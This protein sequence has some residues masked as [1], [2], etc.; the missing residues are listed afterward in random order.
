MGEGFDNY[1]RALA[2]YRGE[3]YAA[4]DFTMSGGTSIASRVAK[5]DGAAWQAVPGLS[6]SNGIQALAV[7]ED[8][9]IVSG[10]VRLAPSG[11]YSTVSSW[12][13]AAW[14]RLGSPQPGA[15][16]LAMEELN[17][18]LFAVGGFLA[19]SGNGTYTDVD[20]ARWSTPSADYNHD[21][22][23]ATDQDIE[24]FFACIA[25]ACCPLC[26]SDFNGDG[27]VATDADIEAFF[28]VLAGGAC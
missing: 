5:W 23:P 26:E 24:D 9:L 22:A 28:R 16:T 6:Y 13:G 17:G 27:A 4:G 2:V 21:G 8:R 3:L 12:D 15:G 10:A 20:W 7:H 1:V 14:E 25:G 11:L 19:I 18:E